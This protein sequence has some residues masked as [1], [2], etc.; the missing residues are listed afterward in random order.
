MKGVVFAGDRQIEFASFADPVPGPGE[1]VL[2]IKASGMCG[3]DLNSIAPQGGAGRSASAS[4]GP[5]IAGHEPCGVV[6]AVGTGSASNARRRRARDGA[7]LQRLRR[8]PALSD[9]LV[10]ALRDGVAEVYG[11]TGMAHMRPT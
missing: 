9:R 7:P 11:V 3:S 5:V 4:G 1:V 8:L 10:A 2:E 6:A